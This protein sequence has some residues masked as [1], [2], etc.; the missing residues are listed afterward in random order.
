MK[1]KLKT[2]GIILLIFGG[3]VLICILI[4]QFLAPDFLNPLNG[5]QT[6]H[7]IFKIYTSEL[8]EISN[9]SKKANKT[10]FIP[11]DFNSFTEIVVPTKNKVAINN[12]FAIK[13]IKLVAD[14][15]NT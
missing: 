4:F 1:N 6:N 12:R 11:Y 3:I 5:L 14:T 15:G 2:I 7:F 8:T 13:T 9:Q 10:G